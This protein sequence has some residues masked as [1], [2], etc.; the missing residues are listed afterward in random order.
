M[1]Y[2]TIFIIFV[3]KYK[4]MGKIAKRRFFASYHNLSEETQDMIES[5]NLY[6]VLTRNMNDEK[7]ESMELVDYF[8]YEKINSLRF[9]MSLRTRFNPH[10]NL[11][12][13]AVYL[14][15]EM[16]DVSKMDIHDELNALIIKY[17]FV[18]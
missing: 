10:R 12:M 7:V 1:F 5:H 2:N 13:K 18:I 6:F 17:S 11:E 14:P 16:G 9:K 4:T 15:K 3:F 8:D